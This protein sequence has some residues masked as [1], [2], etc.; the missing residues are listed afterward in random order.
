MIKQKFHENTRLKLSDEDLWRLFWVHC[1][2][3]QFL[4]GS[5]FEQALLSFRTCF[6]SSTANFFRKNLSKFSYLKL[7]THSSFLSV[8]IAYFIPLVFPVLVCMSASILFIGWM[9]VRHSK[10]TQRSNI[11]RI[12][13]S[14]YNQWTIFIGGDRSFFAAHFFLSP[15]RCLLYE[16]CVQDLLH[17]KV[18]L[19][20]VLYD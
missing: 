5:L 10:L 4:L 20:F 6:L 12:D 9:F 11:K 13:S 8:W 14:V 15:I 18:L 17:P 3:S 1:C 2:G 7:P 16:E 19:E